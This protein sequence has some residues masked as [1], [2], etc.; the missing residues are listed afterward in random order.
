MLTSDYVESPF[1]SRSDDQLIGT[2]G[3]DWARWRA[4]GWTVRAQLNY[5]DNSSNVA[6]YDYDRIDAGLSVRREFR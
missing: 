6:L 3:Y 5:I 4:L 2:L 1:G